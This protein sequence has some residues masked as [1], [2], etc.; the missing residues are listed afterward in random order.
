M[1]LQKFLKASL[2]LAAVGIFNFSHAEEGAGFHPFHVSLFAGATSIQKHTDATFGIDIERRLSRQFGIGPIGDFAVNHRAHQIAALGF[3]F[4]FNDRFKMV[5]APGAEFT[6]AHTDFLFRSGF[7]YDGHI[8]E[9]FSI[10]PAV[11]ADFVRG[12]AVAWVYG[13]NLGFGF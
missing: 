10:G 12:H 2:I 13:I 6:Y 4:H 8:T 7:A 3:F 5:L 1:M 9:N 11:N